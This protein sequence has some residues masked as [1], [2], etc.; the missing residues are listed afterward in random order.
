M[1][2]LQASHFAAA[3]ATTKKMQ[4]IPGMRSKETLQH[5]DAWPHCE[6]LLH[7]KHVDAC[8]HVLV[9]TKHA[10]LFTK[11]PMNCSTAASIVFTQPHATCSIQALVCSSYAV[12]HRQMSCTHICPCR[13]A[14]LL[15]LLFE[16]AAIVCMLAL[17]VA[18]HAP[19]S[20]MLHAGCVPRLPK[21]WT[22]PHLRVAAGL[23]LG[24]RPLAVAV[25]VKAHDKVRQRIRVARAAPPRAARLAV[26]HCAPAVPPGD[27]LHSGAAS[28]AAA[29]PPNPA[30]CIGRNQRAPGKP[31]ARLARGA[32]IAAARVACT[33][34]TRTRP[35]L[36][37][38]TVVR[39]QGLAAPDK[40]RRRLAW[41]RTPVAYIATLASTV[42]LSAIAHSIG[43]VRA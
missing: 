25:T 41:L 34:G 2:P 35:P 39:V 20:C 14:M 4:H 10:T 29:N 30:S 16:N 38:Y 9:G 22:K 43:P 26:A 1:T 19:P 5:T 15:A 23:P 32:P 42:S 12:M 7:E 24:S 31:R 3:P 37:A 17:R 33:H 11:L 27:A 13:C 28:E 21:T 8:R 36:D 18:Q 40:T 6:G